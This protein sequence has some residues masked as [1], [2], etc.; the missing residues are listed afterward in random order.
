MRRVETFIRTAELGLT[1]AS[2]Y[3]AA[4][5][6]LQTS[7]YAKFKPLLLSLL[8]YAE[9]LLGRLHVDLTFLDFALLA[10]ALFLALL[11]WRRGDEAG[12]GRLFSLNMLMFF[13][14][15]LDFSMFNW[16]SLILQYE[17]APH[18]SASPPSGCSA[19]ASSSRSPTL[20][21][22]TP[23]GSAGS[24]RSSSTGAPRWRTWTPSPG[25]R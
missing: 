24:G 9:P 7:L 22:G 19:S 12:F 8:A 20:P 10:L 14:A 23:C 16:V 6:L 13:P 2:T 17:P 21:S 1:L 3:M 4:V 25:A 5:T 15:V 11:F 18:I